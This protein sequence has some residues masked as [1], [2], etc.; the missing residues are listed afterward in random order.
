MTRVYIDGAP[1]TDL[2]WL[3][4]KVQSDPAL[5]IGVIHVPLEKYL[6]G[7]WL[8]YRKALLNIAKDWKLGP[9]LFVGDMNSAIG[10]LDEETEY[11]QGY[12]ESFMYPMENLGWR[13][14]FRAFHPAADA[15]TWVSR[16]GRGFRLDQAFVNAELQ[17][18]VTSCNHNWGRA[19]EKKH[20]SD[21]AAIL[22]D[23][24]LS[25]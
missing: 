13:D 19:T 8:E 22:L 1:E 3:L 20:L 15:P 14:T 10:G 9:S 6:P 4:A 16:I 18:R 11:S 23:L 24:N 12:K 5:H 21:H 7:F 17:A 2:Y 25:I